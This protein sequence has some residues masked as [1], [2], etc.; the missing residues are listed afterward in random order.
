MLHSGS[1][2]ERAEVA[3]GLHNSLQSLLSALKRLVAEVERAAVVCLKNEEAHGHRAVGLLEK[4]VCAGEQLA[5]GDE[6][7][8][9][10]AHLLAVDG[11]HIVVHPI[12]HAHASS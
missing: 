12:L 5:E 2:A 1:L 7:A 9:R 10:L 11:N 4:R 8:E 3:V 6:V